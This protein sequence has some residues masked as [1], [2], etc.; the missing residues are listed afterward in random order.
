MH[1]VTFGEI[2]HVINSHFEKTSLRLGFRDAVEFLSQHNQY[3][4]GTP[5][6]PDFL[7]WNMQNS[8]DL[9]QLIYKIP[10]PLSEILNTVPHVDIDTNQLFLPPGTPVR[11]C[12]EP[13]YAP[14]RFTSLP[15]FAVIYI[16][17]GNCTLYT[18]REH[19]QM[20][21]GEVAL[22]SPNYPYRVELSPEDMVFN[23][24]SEPKQFEQHFLPLVQKDNMLS[25]FFRNALFLSESELLFFML[26]PNLEIRHIIKHLFWEFV[27]ADTFSTDIFR[28]YL[29][30]FYTEI[31]RSHDRTYRYYEN[32]PQI[33]A[34]NNIPAILRYIQ[35]NYHTLTLD[36]LARQ[37]H[38]TPTYLSKVIKETTGQKYTDII[39]DLKIAE[40][41]KLLANSELSIAQIADGAGYHSADHFA[42]TFRLETGLSPREY[43]KSLS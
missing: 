17:K 39:T 2:Q 42:H 13:S 30:I 25:S 27:F 9:R 34:R 14:E 26:A 15:Y 33:N 31:I 24:I 1:Y 19:Y 12:M 32:N 11:I 8:E 23:I 36:I 4:H 18:S 35:E 37:F 6:I 16:F 7:S 43:R 29:Q 28:N 5:T 21:T 22:L 20:K 41:K 40:A 38:Y 3:H 10:V